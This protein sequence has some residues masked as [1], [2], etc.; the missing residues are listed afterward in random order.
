MCAMY[1]IVY[2]TMYSIFCVLHSVL[3]YVVFCFLCTV[4]LSVFCIGRREPDGFEQNLQETEN[5]VTSFLRLRHDW[6]RTVNVDVLL[7]TC[8]MMESHTEETQ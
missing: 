7:L 2:C 4:Y 1:Y 3:Y 8:W 5:P 6:W